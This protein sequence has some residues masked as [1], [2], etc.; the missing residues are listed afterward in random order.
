M[1]FNGRC[2][3]SEE[4]REYAERAEKQGFD[5]ISVN[6]HIIF[7]TGW[8][9]PL[10][11]LAIATTATSKIKLGTSILN[12]VVRNPVIAS[13]ALSSLDVL[14]SGRLF[15]G[16]GPG[17][18]KPDYD[19]CGLAFKERW[20]RFSESLEVLS[21][22]WSGSPASYRGKFYTFENLAMEPKPIQRP[23]PPIW[24]GSWG[25]DWGLRRVARYGDGWMASAYNVTPEG[26]SERWRKLC[27]YL[28]ELGKDPS[29]MGNAVVTMFIYLSENREK[30]WQVARSTLAPALG[31]PPEDLQ[32]LLPFGTPEQCVEKIRRLAESGVRRVFVW[33][34][35][36]ELEQ[37]EIFSEEVMPQFLA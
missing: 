16:V 34:I 2:P 15:A 13:Q 7:R 27:H 20:P 37:M 33:P 5:F 28:E 18:H 19:A 14:S 17:S 11:S 35:Q 25:S 36:D 26:F 22:L 30:A 29:S 21:R 10:A 24:I 23:H 9:D 8:L 3:D 6:D 4:I 12:I 32:R 1:M 31:R